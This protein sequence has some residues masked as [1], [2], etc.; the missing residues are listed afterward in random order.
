MKGN[1]F[2]RN[3]NTQPSTAAE[4]PQSMWNKTYVNKVIY[5]GHY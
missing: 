5:H 1:V 4:R 3:H 2:D